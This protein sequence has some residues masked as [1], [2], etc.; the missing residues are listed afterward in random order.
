MVRRRRA[1]GDVGAVAVPAA[2]GRPLPAALDRGLLVVARSADQLGAAASDAD[3]HREPGRTSRHVQVTLT[4]VV[5]W[6]WL[7]LNV[8]ARASRRAAEC[9][10]PDRR[11][12][13]AGGTAAA[14]ADRARNPS[15]ADPREP[16]TCEWEIVSTSLLLAVSVEEAAV[17][18]RPGRGWWYC[19]RTPG[20]LRRCRWLPR[21]APT[22]RCGV[23]VAGARRGARA[24]RR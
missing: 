2:R 16:V 22:W 5:S 10:Q 4:G 14:V 24:A 1:A 19:P 3:A 15:K 9:R 12:R 17:S 8:D 13:G 6:L 7:A 11:C 18:G 21:A 20:R 23:I